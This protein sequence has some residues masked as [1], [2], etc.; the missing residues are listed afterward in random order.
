MKHELTAEQWN[1]EY[2]DALERAI[3]RASRSSRHTHADGYPCRGCVERAAAG[4]RKEF[5][6]FRRVQ[7][8]HRV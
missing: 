1:D 2:P 8:S 6:V 3:A 7:R 4:V 5:D